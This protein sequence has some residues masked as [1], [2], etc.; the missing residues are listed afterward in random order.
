MK[1]LTLNNFQTLIK[2]SAF[3]CLIFGNFAD[4]W[5]ILVFLNLSKYQDS[6]CLVKSPAMTN[7]NADYSTN[8]YSSRIE[9][10]FLLMLTNFLFLFN[11][12]FPRLPWQNKSKFSA[13]KQFISYTCCQGVLVII[14]LRMT[15]CCVMDIMDDQNA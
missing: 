3:I 13:Q 2:Q 4:I 12:E 9:S 11:Q 1:A 14:H 6:L 5:Q 8:V 7:L 15:M 10:V